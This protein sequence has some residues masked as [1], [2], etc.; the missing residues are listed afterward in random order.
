[1]A[2]IRGDIQLEEWRPIP[3][4]KEYEAS[5]RGRVRSVNRTAVT[6][7]SIRS[8]S[9]QRFHHGRILRPC[10]KST[11]HLSVVLGRSSGSKD[12]HWLIALTFIGP[13]PRGQ[14]VRHLNGIPS[15]NRLENLE[16]ATRSRNVQDRKWHTP[17][18]TQRLSGQE[19]RD[20]K[21]R[22]TTCAG[23]ELA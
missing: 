15:D 8:Q 19:V 10:T 18:I 3:G 22:L 12:V 11:G 16:Y 7:A 13:C 5:N 6:S 20:I 1:M 14:E 21:Q 2:T 17:A 23:I 4:Y 9:Y